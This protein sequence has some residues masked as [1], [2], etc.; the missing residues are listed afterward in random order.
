MNHC[1]KLFLLLC[2]C[3]ASP[4]ITN[5]D[6]FLRK[7][8]RIDADGYVF[9]DDEKQ[10]IYAINN[11]HYGILPTICYCKDK[12]C[13]CIKHPKYKNLHDF[14]MA[15][16]GRPFSQ[17]IKMRMESKTSML[18]YCEYSKFYIPPEKQTFHLQ[19]A[20]IGLMCVLIL[21]CVIIL[22]KDLEGLRLFVMQMAKAR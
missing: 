7:S 20:I 8:F 22:G 6:V 3:E 5:S 11:K 9:I 2:F 4:N 10:E 13:E 21:G 19:F 1:I 18:V 17:Y 15:H 12:R 14:S 16:Y